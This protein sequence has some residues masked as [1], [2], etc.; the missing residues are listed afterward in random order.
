MAL[1]FYKQSD[2]DAMDANNIP[3]R[4]K[5]YFKSLDYAG[6]VAILGNRYDLAEALGFKLPEEEGKEDYLYSDSENE[7]PDIVDSADNEAAVNIAQEESEESEEAE[8]EIGEEYDFSQISHNSYEGQSFAYIIQNNMEPLEALALKNNVE[9][10]PLHHTPLKKWQIKYTQ[11]GM[12]SMYVYTCEECHRIFMY[13][14]N[15]SYI[16]DVLVDKGVAHTFYNLDLTNHYLRS[17][18]S[19]YE[20]G[21]DEKVYVPDLWIEEAPICPVHGIELYERPCCRSYKDRKVSFT[22]YVCEKCNKIMVRRAYI[23][24]L[25]DQCATIGVPAIEHESI[26]KKVPKKKPLPQKEVKPDY[27][28]ENGKR[29]KYA[30]D[31]IA[32]CYKLT[33]EDTVVVTDSIYCTLEGHDTEEVLAMIWV[34]QKRGG[35]KSYLFVVGYCAHCQKYYMDI[36]DYNVVYSIGRPE[37]TILSDID[38]GDY[39]ITSG[40]VFNLEKKHLGNLERGIAGEIASIQHSSDYVNPYAVG[41]YDDGNLSFAKSHSKQKYGQRLEDLTG[42]IN[43]P[44]SY[45]VDISCDDDTETFYIGAS[46]IVLD[47]GKKV[48]SANSEL[49]YELINY[50]TISVK[51]NGKDYNIKLSRQ[52]DIE[53]AALYGYVNLRTDEDVIFKSGIT[54]PFLVRVL[55]LRKRQHNLTDIFVTIQENQNK[56]VNSDFRKNIIVQGCAGSGKTMVL[57][58]RLSALKYRNNY[59]DFSSKAMILTPNEQFSLHIKGL[60]EGLQIG[61]IHRVSVEQYYIDML[62]QYDKVFKPENKTSSEMFVRQDYVDYIYSDQFRQDFDD[63]YDKVI[64]DRNRLLDALN[65]LT[66]AMG[67]EQR[68]ISLEDDSRVIPQLKNAAEMMSGIV[69][70]QDQVVDAAKEELEKHI[71]RKR[72]LEKRIPETQQFASGIVKETLSRVY[73]KIA[74]YMKEKED[75]ISEFENQLQILTEEQ[76]KVQKAFNPFGKRAKLEQLENDIQKQKDVISKAKKQLDVEKEIFSEPQDE[77]T[78]EEIVSWMRLVAQYIKSVQEDVRLCNNTKEEFINYSQEF[79][80]IDQLISDAEEKYNDVQENQYPD[81]VKRMI[82]YLN[83]KVGEYGI[84]ETYQMV[85]DEAVHKF[86]E[87]ND[88]KN[89]NGKYHRY[90][91]YAQLLFAMKFF[92]RV[93]GTL[94]FMCIDEG[95][96]LALN[97]YRLISELNQRNVIYNIFGDTNQLM[98]PGRGIADWTALEKEFS[99]QMFTLNENYRNTNQI[100]KFCNSSFGMDVLQTGVDGPSV[101]EIPRRDLEKELADL[102]VTTERIAILVPRGVQKKKYIDTDILPKDIA[103]LIGD[104]MDNGYIAVMYVDEVKGI[105]FDKV[106]VVGNKMTRNEKYIAYTRALSELILVVDDTVQDYDDGHDRKKTKKATTDQKKKS[107]SGIL[108]YKSGSKNEHLELTGVQHMPEMDENKSDNQIISDKEAKVCRVPWELDEPPKSL[109][110]LNRVFEFEGVGSIPFDYIKVLKASRPQTEKVDSL[111]EYYKKNRHLDKPIT[112]SCQNGEYVLE[113]KFLRYYVARELGLKFID[114]E[115]GTRK[116]NKEKDKLRTLNT[117][118]YDSNENDNG[119]VVDVTLSCIKIKFSSGI[120]K[121]YDINR[122]YKSGVVSILDEPISEK[123]LTTDN[124]TMDGSNDYQQI[125]FSIQDSDILLSEESD[126]SEQF[127]FDFSEPERKSGEE[128]VVLNSINPS[129]MDV[130]V[131]FEGVKEIPMKLIKLPGYFK[132]AK[133]SP[134]K[135]QKTVEYYQEHGRFDKP[136]TVQLQDDN[137]LLKDKYLRYYVAKKLNLESIEAEFEDKK[138]EVIIP[139]EEIDGSSTPLQSIAGA[140]LK[141]GSFVK[142]KYTDEEIRDALTN[143]FSISSKKDTSY[144]FVFLKSILDCMYEVENGFR[145]SFDRL[146]QRFTEIYWPMVVEYDLHQKVGEDSL[147]YVEKILLEG[148][149]KYGMDANSKFTDLTKNQQRNIVKTVKQKCKQ[150]VVGALYGD[151]KRIFYSFSK[152][153]E[154]IEIN[155]LV[156]HFL[157]RYDVNDFMSCHQTAHTN[158]HQIA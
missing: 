33:E 65:S 58:H 91:F 134:D 37:V 31:H 70:R 43:K 90:D 86:K 112:V 125:P 1:N 52:F 84:L 106:F 32:D 74:T 140:T 18:M 79:S 44:Y 142:G 116:D 26:A 13:E 77:K 47:N 45:R 133:P 132:S 88:V 102:N 68:I 137:Y 4:F 150:N 117:M 158:C 148:A 105:E 115:I 73:A 63:A 153:D 118:I 10:C 89:I 141:E 109:P 51:R 127:N 56:I 42:Y 156:F 110:L 124:V 100:T 62:M 20:I 7:I 139:S 151:T 22:G 138:K 41:D 3:V 2:I 34:N 50:Q 146:F 82:K 40:E 155:P 17:Q 107:Y 60:A 147:S 67:Q 46:D 136:I 108:T 36:D 96:D 119:I 12:Y 144:K 76:L 66:E 5:N 23:D 15:M 114:C 57:L 11:N 101:R 122:Y 99:A 48:I 53:N 8:E 129:I 16:H 120:E 38:D 28:I 87:E 75:A 14:E 59:F 54:D 49:G 111:I 113:D 55:N 103:K 69:Q 94:E 145:L 92:K 19:E 104:N 78:D 29:E 131:P 25:Q 64:A 135:V 39:Q 72:F 143:V 97:E 93:Y 30:Y 24:E 80:E 85:F 149:D 130:A 123:V 128:T 61:S 21:T 126:K 98:K 157:M 121:W 152:K 27:I 95:Q 83:L 9:K 81:D 6:K 154:W 35:R 71:I